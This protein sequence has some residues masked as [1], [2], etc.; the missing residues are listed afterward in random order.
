[1]TLRLEHPTDDAHGPDISGHD[2][3]RDIAETMGEHDR[4]LASIETGGAQAAADLVAAHRSL[5]DDRCRRGLTLD[6]AQVLRDC[7]RELRDNVRRVR[8]V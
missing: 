6:D 1:M 8:G 5:V 3:Q 4:V 2:V 7:A